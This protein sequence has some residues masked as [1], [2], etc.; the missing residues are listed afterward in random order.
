MFSFKAPFSLFSFTF[1]KRLFSSSSLSAIRVVSSACLR[2]LI[3]LLAILILACDSS[4][5]AFRMCSAYKLN[6]QG[7][8]S[9]VVF[10]SQFWTS[11]LFHRG[12]WLLLPDPHTGFSR[13]RY[14]G[15]ITKT[16]HVTDDDTGPTG[17]L[18]ATVMGNKRYL[19]D[20]WFQLSVAQIPLTGMSALWL[21]PDL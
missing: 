9:L 21:L 10:L 3:F 1:I 5:L 15:R 18:D 12:F 7:D 4:S 16:H 2:L 11:Q 19:H 8:N 13:D 6:K 20:G 17:Q 14:Y